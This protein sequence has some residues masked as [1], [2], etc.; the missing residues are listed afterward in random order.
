[1][2]RRNGG[3]FF[4]VYL[5]KKIVDRERRRRGTNEGAKGA[6]NRCIIGE[7]PYFTSLFT[8]LFFSSLSLFRAG[9]LQDARPV[10]E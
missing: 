1:M 2:L 9:P 8:L 6:G 5:G 4:V 7:A 10:E 3:R